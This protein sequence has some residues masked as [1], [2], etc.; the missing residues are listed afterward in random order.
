MCVWC[1]ESYKLT[2][3]KIH[4]ASVGDDRGMYRVYGLDDY[5]GL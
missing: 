2:A 4:D 5:G 3:G 1:L